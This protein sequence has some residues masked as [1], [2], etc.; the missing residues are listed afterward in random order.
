MGGIGAR[1]TPMGTVKLT[2][3]TATHWWTIYITELVVIPAN[4]GIP[5]R[6]I[7]SET[8]IATTV[9]YKVNDE[10][11]WVMDFTT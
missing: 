10:V 4:L 2:W 8:K 9:Y 5:D 7:L 11:G 6:I 1:V 3:H